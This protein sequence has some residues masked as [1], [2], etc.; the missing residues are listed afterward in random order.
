MKKF[1]L[2]KPG[3]ESFLYAD[4]AAKGQVGYAEYPWEQLDELNWFK[5]LNN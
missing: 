2:D 5:S 3:K 4:I 1:H